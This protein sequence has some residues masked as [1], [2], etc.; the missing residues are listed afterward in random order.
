M[1]KDEIQII[2]DISKSLSNINNTIS[3]LADAT[4]NMVDI[5]GKQTIDIKLI[6]EKINYL[7][8]TTKEIASVIEQVKT[9]FEI[10][11]RQLD[12]QEVSV[13]KQKKIAEHVEKKFKKEVDKVKQK[14]N[15][16]EKSKDENKFSWGKFIDAAISFF[17]NSKYIFLILFIIVLLLL[18]ITNRIILINEI[19]N[20]F[21]TI[22]GA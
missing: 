3:N 7:K 11:N 15:E 16:I 1:D 17:E 9:K 18:I 4:R 20:W 6:D 2:I 14:D 21:K 5:N 10:L 22:L 13:I 8:E 12:Y 19:T